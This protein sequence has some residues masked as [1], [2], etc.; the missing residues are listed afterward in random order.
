[1]LVCTRGRQTIKVN[2]H[3]NFYPKQIIVDKRSIGFREIGQVWDPLTLWRTESRVMS[4]S[5]WKSVMVPNLRR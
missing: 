4:E 1:M 2:T 5:V 3:P